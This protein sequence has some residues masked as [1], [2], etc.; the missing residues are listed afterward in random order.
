[1]IMNYKRNQ[2]RNCFQILISAFKT[3]FVKLIISSKILKFN[4]ITMKITQ[5]LAIGKES[6]LSRV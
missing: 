3:V 4:L 2:E 5:S 1:M 6:L